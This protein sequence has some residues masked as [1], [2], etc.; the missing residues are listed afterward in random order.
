M[1][2]PPPVSRCLV[3]RAVIEERSFLN[4]VLGQPVG[5]VRCNTDQGCTS[6]LCVSPTRASQPSSMASLIVA[7]SK[8]AARSLLCN[9]P[10]HVTCLLATSRCLSN[11]KS[12]LQGCTLLHTYPSSHPL[13]QAI[14][15]KTDKPSPVL[16]FKVPADER[17]TTECQVLAGAAESA[18][19]LDMVFGGTIKAAQGK[20]DRF[21]K[22]LFD[23]GATWCFIH[24]GLVQKLGLQ[25]RPSRLKAVATAAGRAESI[26]GEVSFQILWDATACEVTAHV[27]GTFLA[28]VDLI[29]GQDF[30][31]SNHV[32]MDY[33]AARCT[34]TPKGGEQVQLSRLA[35][36]TKDS[37]PS[38]SSTVEPPLQSCVSA[39]VAAHL[40][41]RHRQHAFVA[42][43]KPYQIRDSAPDSHHP[44][45]Q[46]PPDQAPACA[47]VAESNKASSPSPNLEHVP[48]AF[49]AELEKLLA[50]FSDIFSESPQ[51]GGARVDVPEHAI[52]L[53]PDAKP[54][55][56]RNYRLSPLEM[57][58]L[59]KQVTEFLSKGIVTP[60]NSPFGA[61]VLFIPKP[62]GGGL[63]FCLDYRALND[64]TV[65]LRY[66]LPR[67]DDLLDAARGA[68]C[69]SALDLAS[70]Y[71]QIR[72]AEEDIPKTAFS[73]PFGHFEWR[74]LP[75][76]LTNAPS[77]FM[78]AMNTVFEP[79]LQDFV[80]VY[81]DDILIMSKTPDQHL[82]HLRRV[83]EKLRE[84][85]FQVK[86]S[87]CKF[88]KD[89]IK[90]LGHILS[91]DGVRPDPGKV[92]TLLD[93][94]MPDTALGMQQFLG[95]ANYFR[96]FIPNYSRIAAPLC[97]L[98]K[99][100]VGFSVGEEARLAF[101]AVKA[102]LVSPPLLAY[103]DPDL[104]YELI[105]DASI[106]GCGA[107]LVQEGRPVAYFSSKFSSAEHNYTTGE[108]EMLGIIK[109]LK[110]WR[111][112]LE[113]CK[114]LTLVTDHNPL[115]FFSVQPTLSRR[116]ARWQEFLSRFHFVVKYRPGAINPADPL[117]R[118]HSTAG[119]AAVAV[120]AVTV[121]EYQPELLQSIR[122]ASAKDPHF[123][124]AKA[125]RKYEEQA[126]Y[127]T[128]QGR[129]VVPAEMQDDIISRHHS[130]VTAGHFSWKRTLDFVARQFWWPQMR[131]SVKSFVST[132][133]S[134]QRTKATNH[135]PYGLLNPLEI[136][137]ERWHTVT[138]DFIMDLPRSATCNDAI[139]VWVDKLTKYVHLVPTQKTC[140]AEELARLFIKHIFQF[141]GLPK[142]LISDRDPR[143]TSRFWKELCKRLNIQPRFSTAFH[144]QTDGQTERANRVIEEVLR[145]FVDK[146]HSNWEEL[147]PLVAFAMNNAK[148]ASHG[149]TPFF[150]NYGTHPVNPVELD[151]PMG[152]M[153]TLDRVLGD[154]S[155]TLT[156][157]KE[158]LKAAQDR[159]SE[160]A[161][162]KRIPHDFKVGQKVLLSTRNLKFK[163]G[164]RKLH[165]AWIGPFKIE[166]M[167]G[168]NA[169]KLEL[170]AEYSR[171]H[172]VFHVSLLK[173]YK[174]GVKA[175]KPPAPEL[176]A[177]EL[178][179]KV[180][181]ILSRRQR[182]SGRKQ[183]TEYLVKWAG[184]DDTHNSWEPEENLTPDLLVAYKQ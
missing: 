15:G 54:P 157:V 30:L 28:E 49:K 42:V 105:S 162:A 64:L 139:L 35:S 10:P 93:W 48:P 47:A 180:E 159:Q 163:T 33:S 153:P 38:P 184:Y 156:R 143:F 167:A 120:L 100:G 104:P 152:T 12:T 164:V 39:A 34:L 125:T 78:R 179:Y 70:G 140:S 14:N 115:T 182:R 8:E 22:C 74:V 96:K 69:F 137:D 135:K 171:L 111:C 173:P 148:S 108:Q 18:P 60:S 127:W 25:V 176:I 92:Q 58:E 112:Y 29:L 55:F 73:T 131:E 4:S 146:E 16:V 172:P 65:K 170:P 160:Y 68:E 41:R 99:K 138:F 86:L 136:P 79:Y 124:D 59:R 134:C 102:Q 150:L 83:F 117:S 109:A 123:Q 19:L 9:R 110:E 94:A 23:S 37:H 161:D 67:I 128:Y 3:C 95:L 89:Q 53:L 51:A 126:G 20:R 98:T 46:A 107:V 121:S 71:Y 24:Q 6:P 11:L 36:G 114:G 52:T 132:C 44:P 45:P 116:Q 13:G 26:L 154:M 118:L 57:Q 181:R 87:K 151:L 50:E 72:I 149:E 27:L 141:H 2:G 82:V 1:P 106:T 155:H 84:Y 21:A 103:P 119:T 75:M 177:G 77:S 81:L 88:L 91:K 165:P 31:K 66:P 56:R 142:K 62:N 40:L 32:I 63:R 76:G 145:H 17:E 147:L 101:D 97:H 133:D 129:I 178:Y 169:A 7:H 144:P 122:E 183:V 90:Y 43:V 168:K 113:G 61:P 80:L 166:K 158:L 174:E 85:R 175:L 130:H 5:A